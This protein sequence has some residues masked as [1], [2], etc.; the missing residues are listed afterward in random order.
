M[1]FYSLLWRSQQQA[2]IGCQVILYFRIMIQEGNEL[3]QSLSL[4]LSFL[5]LLWQVLLLV[6][7]HQHKKHN[8][9]KTTSCLGF[10]SCMNDSYSPLSI[11]AL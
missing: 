10:M 11:C 6:G 7:L 3:Q 5:A 9:K 4:R 8:G 2:N 1:F